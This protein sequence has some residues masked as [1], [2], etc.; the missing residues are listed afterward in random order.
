MA[1]IHIGAGIKVLG[2]RLHHVHSAS[3]RDRLAAIVWIYNDRLC[4]P[5]LLVSAT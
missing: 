2:W 3:G 4:P 1:A 5:V